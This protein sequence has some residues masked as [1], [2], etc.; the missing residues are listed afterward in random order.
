MGVVTCTIE[1][2]NRNKG[3]AQPKKQKQE[4]EGGED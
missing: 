1:I 2:G 4:I 3:R